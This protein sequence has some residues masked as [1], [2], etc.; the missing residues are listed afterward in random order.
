MRKNSQP[1]KPKPNY[2]GS[3]QAAASML[4]I[5]LAV[6]RAAKAAG[7]LAFRGTRVEIGILAAW[8]KDRAAKQPAA[9]VAS[10][11]EQPA[12]LEAGASFALRRLEIEEANAH[13]RYLTAPGE[14]S[15][16]VW[17]QLSEQLRKADIALEAARRD[18]SESL[19]RDSAERALRFACY[20]LSALAPGVAGRLA[21]DL[22][23][24]EARGAIT[25]AIRNLVHSAAATG[26]AGAATLPPWAVSAMRAGAE[27]ALTGEAGEFAG[28]LEAV[29]E[30]LKP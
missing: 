12:P 20:W 22:G 18:S 26:A 9:P 14:D 27:V 7:C 19:P 13:A 3:Q 10:V 21:V 2:A 17:L 5:S 29:R 4:G 24:P 16:K 28:K 11:N 25:L 15:L 8:L 23:R 1:V 6:V 30:V